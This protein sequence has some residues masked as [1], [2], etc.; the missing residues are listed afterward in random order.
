MATADKMIGSSFRVGHRTGRQFCAA[1]FGLILLLAPCPVHAGWG[2]VDSMLLLALH[3]GMATFDFLQGRF[4]RP[5][6]SSASPEGHRLQARADQGRARLARLTSERERARQ[7]HLAIVMRRENTL[8]EMMER[9]AT[10]RGQLRDHDQQFREYERRY[11]ASMAE[12]AKRLNQVENELNEAQDDVSAPFFLTRQET[13]KRLAELQKELLAVIDHVARQRGLSVV[14]DPT[15]AGSVPQ[16]TP[17][18]DG[19]EMPSP[20]FTGPRQFQLFWNYTPTTTFGSVPGPDG[21]PVSGEQHISSALYRSMVQNMQTYLGR[22]SFLTP[23][24]ARLSFGTPSAFVTG[25]EDIT[26]T[27]ASTLFSRYRVAADL[28]QRLIALIR[29]YRAFEEETP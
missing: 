6:F 10:H 16:R 9:E 12:A 2:Q 22:L 1:V 28:Q 19:A 7:N 29:S 24:L 18:V 14:L 13:D 21:Q 26:E 17:A 5:S 20:D 3:P 23:A 15:F 27:V 25:G 4:L 11:E 8:R